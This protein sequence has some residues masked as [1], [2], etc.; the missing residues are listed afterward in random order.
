MS[1]DDREDTIAKETVCTE[2][3]YK[4]IMGDKVTASTTVT[5]I[6]EW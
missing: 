3:N 5:V 2:E 4:I 1:T 6:L